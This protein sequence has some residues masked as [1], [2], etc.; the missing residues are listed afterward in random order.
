MHLPILPML[1]V[2]HRRQRRVKT[3]TYHYKYG[4]L[5]FPGP[6][7]DRRWAPYC[8]AARR[9]FEPGGGAAGNAAKAPGKGPGCDL[10]AVSRVFEASRRDALALFEAVAYADDPVSPHHLQD[11]VGDLQQN[12]RNGAPEPVMA[13]AVGS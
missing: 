11:V 7:V 2:C 12:I 5:A 10:L 4:L 9:W 6:G 8:I 1:A 13:A 3:G